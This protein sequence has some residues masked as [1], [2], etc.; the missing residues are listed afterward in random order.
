M[1]IMQTKHKQFIDKLVDT[2]K[3]GKFKVRIG[4]RSNTYSYMGI[5][6]TLIFGVRQKTMYDTNE[7][8]YKLEFYLPADTGV[9]ANGDLYGVTTSTKIIDITYKEFETL[10]DLLTRVVMN[11]KDMI[12]DELGKYL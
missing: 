1:L 3:N 2:I 12:Y 10:R 6:D 8:S 7:T 4:N 5:S 9:Q 11:E